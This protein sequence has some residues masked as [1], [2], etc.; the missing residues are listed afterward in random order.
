MKKLFSILFIIISICKYSIIQLNAQVVDVSRIVPATLAEKVNLITDRSL[1]CVREKLFFVA[2]YTPAEHIK[3]YNWSNVLYVE[4]IRWNGDKL[5]QAKYQINDS[6]ISG[7]I[8]IPEDLNSGNYYLRAYTNWMRNYS[9]SSYS[10]INIKIVN[11]NKPIIDEGPEMESK[12]QYTIEIAKDPTSIVKGVK[13]VAQTNTYKSRQK[14]NLDITLDNSIQSPSEIFYIT[15]AK[16]GAIQL[17]YNSI[18]QNIGVQ[19]K[20]DTIK[21]L[22]EFRGATVTGLVIN[23]T[24]REPIEKI[25]VRLSIPIRGNYYSVYKTNANGEFYFTLP[26][27]Y[28]KPDI[29][30][31]I[32]A[33]PPTEAEILIN[34][35][36][37]NED[38]Y[39]PYIPFKLE[40][41]EREIAQELMINEQ[42]DELFLN[43][44]DNQTLLAG[45]NDTTVFYG[46][47]EKVYYTRDFIELP[48]LEEF[49]FEIVSEVLVEFQKEGNTLKIA[50][51]AL[52]QSLSPLILIDNI[53]VYDISKFLKTTLKKIERVEVINSR[54]R[55]GNAFYNGLISIYSKN[56]DFA[57]VDLNPNSIFLSY[58]LLNGNGYSFPT[59]PNSA[60]NSRTPDNRN[61]LYW[62]PGIQLSKNQP[63]SISFFTSDEKGKYVAFVRN[64][65]PDGQLIYG[66]FEFEVE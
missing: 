45:T 28:G 48:N 25:S 21:Y 40:K 16:E 18:A 30:V 57:G 47:P 7:S 6:A 17:N 65:N 43:S 20:H 49:F 29:Y 60:V 1:Y 53:P 51:T 58:G 44:F 52:F 41:G 50:N 14:V 12:K 31:D 33:G 42:I 19:I 5:V 3:A 56:K 39:L 54:Y 37:C 61:L 35:D 55:A 24:T 64:M 62:E 22:P 66:S 36:Y 59:Y 13:C 46:S 27:L 10:Y 4:L 63:T 15:V 32:D 26:E 9:N 38:V 8:E 2:N 34:S 11:P 23:K